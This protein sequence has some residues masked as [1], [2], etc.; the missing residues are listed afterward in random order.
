[1]PNRGRKQA[2]QEQCEENKT[3]HGLIGPWPFVP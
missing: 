3:A 1:L 2:G